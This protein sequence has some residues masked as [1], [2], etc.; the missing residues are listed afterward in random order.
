MTKDKDNKTVVPS[1]RF[2]EFRD[3]E[4]WHN[5]RL[6]DI[7]DKKTKWHFTGGPFGS[8]LKASDY[9]NSGIRVIQLQNIGDG[10]FIEDYKIYTSIEKADELLSCNIY[11]G[12]IIMSKMGDPVG[13]A[14]L[15]PEYEDRYLMCSD[16]IRVV[17]DEDK[18]DKYFI[19]TIINA[20]EFRRKIEQVA[21]GSTRKRISLDILKGL[22]LTIPYSKAEQAKIAD[23]LGN[24]DD[25]ISAVADKI[26][27]LMKYKK[28]LMQQLFPA[29]G[30]TTPTLRFPEFQNAGEW[31]SRT[32]SDVCKLVRGPFGGALKKEIFVEN[33]YA[34]YEQSHAIYGD[35]NIFRYYITEDKFNELI[36]F[37]VRPNDIIMSCSG[38]MGKFSIIPENFTEGVINQALLKLSTKKD[39]DYRFIKFLLELPNNQKQ[40]L[41]DAAGGAI[42]N[43]ASVSLIKEM[44][45]FIP[46]LK[47]Q[48]I[49]ADSLSSVD[50]LI[51]AETDKLEQLKVHKKGLMQQLFPSF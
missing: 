38:T 33:G 50:K 17:V 26:E 36:R 28:G 16:G 24:L 45:L 20:E 7:T 11:P 23:C 14:C 48:Q 3:S 31:K 44:P 47:E 40:L 35:M 49:I 5:M 46:E 43:V 13:R 41:S 39:N 51:S 9:T 12:N 6:I 1:L 15:I 34:V 2:P 42:K 30:K 29:E 27:A 37:A 21:T 10:H 18:N 19:L 4:G 32:L 25:L 22:T 8:N